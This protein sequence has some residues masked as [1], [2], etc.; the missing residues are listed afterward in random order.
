MNPGVDR[1][2]QFGADTVGGRD[3]QR[4][5]EAGGLQIEYATKT[6]DAAVGARPRGRAGQRFDG[7]D[8]T[9]SGIDIDTRVAIGQRAIC[10][11]LA[12]GVLRAYPL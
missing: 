8:E 11:W 10:S 5:G 6:T 2:P 7:I 1:D 3:Q 4:V 12:D 9:L